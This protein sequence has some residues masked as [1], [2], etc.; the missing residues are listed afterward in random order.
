[1]PGILDQTNA[2]LIYS[3]SSLILNTTQSTHINPND[4][5]DNEY[6]QS[7]IQSKPHEVLQQQQQQQPPP[8]TSSSSSNSSKLSES[9]INNTTIDTSNNAIDLSDQ[10]NE[11]IKSSAIVK[12]LS[13]QP[14][15]KFKPSTITIQNISKT[16]FKPLNSTTKTNKDIN[17]SSTTSETNT[18]SS[19]SSTSTTSSTS[20]SSIKTKEIQLTEIKQQCS[21]LIKELDLEDSNNNQNNN[22]TNNNNKFEIIIKKHIIELKK[23]NDLKDI[24]L[25]LIELIANQRMIK[26]DDIL[27]E[28]NLLN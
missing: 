9:T 24:A 1:M 10:S 5:K 26:T 3:P 2:S 25:Q 6:S 14:S 17:E 11:A 13:R 7:L 27:Q 4:I 19:S 15:D 21:N 22:N 18:T 12:T 8:P 23:Y 20:P 28:I 16:N